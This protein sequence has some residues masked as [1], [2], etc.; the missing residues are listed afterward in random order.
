MA[1]VLNLTIGL[2]TPPVGGVLF[3]ITSVS[4]LKFEA[5]CRAIVPFVLAEIAVLALVIFVPALST[6]FPSW[7]GYVR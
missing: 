6:A 4:R 7:L 2:V 1:I 5:I 3:V